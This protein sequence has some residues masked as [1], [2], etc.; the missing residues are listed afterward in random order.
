MVANVV[1]NYPFAPEGNLFQKVDKH[2][3]SLPIDPHH[4]TGFQTNLYTSCIIL[5]QIGPKL[6]I[7][8]KIYVLGKLTIITVFYLTTIF[9]KKYQRAK[10]QTRL[11]NSDPNWAWRC[12][13]KGDLLEKLTNIASVFYIPSCYKISKIS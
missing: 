1:P 10:H 12:P 7:S 8:P 13:P 6:P 2:H 11:H 4:S 9:Q 5:A 3:I